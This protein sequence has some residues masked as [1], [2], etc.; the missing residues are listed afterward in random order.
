MVKRLS[1]IKAE[2]FFKHRFPKRNIE[3]E[4]ET[5]YFYEWVHRFG[6]TDPTPFMDNE[7]VEAYKLVLEDLRSDKI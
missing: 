2:L 6:Y 5:G 3:F 7:S 1:E 4:K